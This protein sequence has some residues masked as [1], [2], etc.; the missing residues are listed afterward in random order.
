MHVCSCPMLTLYRSTTLSFVRFCLKQLFTISQNPIFN[1]P[2]S[3]FQFLR[4]LLSISQSPTFNFSESYFQFIRIHLSISHYPTFNFSVSNFQFLRILLSISQNPARIA[5]ETLPVLEKIVASGRAR[6]HNQVENWLI[7]IIH[8]KIPSGILALLDFPWRN[9]TRCWTS[10]KQKWTQSWPTPRISLSTPVFR[11]NLSNFIEAD[12]F[13]D[14][15]PYFKSKR[16]GVIN[17]SPTGRNPFAI[18]ICLWNLTFIFRHGSS[19]KCR[20]TAMAPRL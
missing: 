13:Q 9:F 19:H 3:Y 14:H 18:K 2:E 6:W 12:F 4:I 5:L 16:L 8:K 7:K 10:P 11:W 15:L 1:F 20:T 17:A